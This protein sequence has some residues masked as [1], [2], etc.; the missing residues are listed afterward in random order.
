M[1]AVYAHV[2]R[3]WGAAIDVSSPEPGRF[4]L[5]LAAD[6]LRYGL[7]AAQRW[8]PARAAVGRHSGATRVLARLLAAA[9]R[10]ERDDLD[11]LRSALLDAWELLRDSAPRLPERP[12]TLRLLSLERSAARTVLA[13]G[14]R[15]HPLLVAKV[16]A[17]GD[18]RAL[19]ESQ[20][21]AAVAAAGIAPRPLGEVGGALVQ[22]G[23]PGRA[24]RVEPL[25]PRRAQTLAWPAQL[26]AASAGVGAV[27]TATR[28]PTRP[29]ADLD[30]LERAAASTALPAGAAVA[31]QAA[32]RRLADLQV[33]VLRHGDLSPQNILMD[34]D[35]LVGFV[36]WELAIHEG[37]PGFDVWHAA[38]SWLE[39]GV[40]LQ[41]W[42]QDVV[43]SAVTS[44]WRDTHFGKG[45]RVA[46][47]SAV[48]SAGVDASLVDDLEVAFF[49]RRWMRRHDGTRSHP[50]TAATAAR[51]L[52]A[53]CAR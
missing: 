33:S 53:V 37:A 3:P 24:L 10:R 14:D 29:A 5:A 41:R 27:A 30:D 26:A 4:L 16:P 12:P 44:A 39:H 8:G 38:L 51:V 47:T 49:A 6:S 31:V 19:A 13:F 48:I 20:V 43:A 46:A 2:R 25:S 28:R 52:E 22:E 50:V 34:D 17:P 7:P 11:A 36:D 21:L 42:A 32:S 1:S 45:V 9:P 15:P 18:E 35:E 40:G 23:L